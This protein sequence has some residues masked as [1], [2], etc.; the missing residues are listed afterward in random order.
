MV[1]PVTRAIRIGRE[2][3]VS[4][5]GSLRTYSR[6]PADS[7]VGDVAFHEEATAGSDRPWTGQSELDG[8]G[9]QPI[10]DVIRVPFG[11]FNIDMPEQGHKRISRA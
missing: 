6:G 9:R 4:T 3:A 11:R 7:L 5:T 1:G 2:V 8:L 10:A